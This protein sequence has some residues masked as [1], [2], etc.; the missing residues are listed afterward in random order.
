V[1]AGRGISSSRAT[2]SRLNGHAPIV[3]AEQG[4]WAVEMYAGTTVF[5]GLSYP[6]F[7]GG[8]GG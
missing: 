1:V 5:F 2:C 4:G 8:G 7:R 3:I 6:W